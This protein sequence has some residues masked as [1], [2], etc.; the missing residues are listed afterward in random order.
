MSIIYFDAAGTLAINS[1]ESN[2][3][4]IKEALILV[5]GTHK[6]NKGVVH[7]FPA[8]RVKRLADNTNKTFE[9]G[10][11]VP[12]MVDH[13]KELIANGE[14]KKLGNWLYPFEVRIITQRDL[15]NP[16]M[17]Q[18]IGKVGAFGKT[19]IHH[20]VEDV[21]NGL[22]KLLSPGID[23]VR[24]RIAE[25][26]AVAFPAIHGPALFKAYNAT[27]AALNYADAKEQF[28]ALRNLKQKAQE[29]FDILF[30]VIREIE[31]APP[32]QMMGIDPNALK[33]KAVDEFIVD[34]TD[35]LGISEV[36][37][38]HSSVE[39]DNRP[40]AYGNLGNYSSPLET[41]DVLVEEVPEEETPRLKMRK[42]R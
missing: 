37:S 20:R 7:Y 10:E 18:L 36:E 34:L 17:V 14:L 26:S 5:E 32:E 41:V 9:E 21:K 22:V 39:D 38:P 13:S 2:G 16:K 35:L 11:E 30:A 12:F 40:D 15:P 23:L 19:A 29:Y 33:R 4:L 42:R 8:S 6:D 27:F 1:V 31:A 3:T 24:D 25:I 28:N